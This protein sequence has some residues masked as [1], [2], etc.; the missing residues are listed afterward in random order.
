VLT[1]EA[2]ELWADLSRQLATADLDGRAL[3]VSCGGALYLADLGLAAQGWRTAT[4][5]LPT[6]PSPTC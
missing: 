3:V 1:P 4:R 6:P 5:R 2:L